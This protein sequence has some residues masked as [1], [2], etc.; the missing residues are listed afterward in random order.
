MGLLLITI[1]LVGYLAWLLYTLVATSRQSL[2]MLATLVKLQS[3]RNANLGAWRNRAGRE[4]LQ[5]RI[6]ERL[7][8]EGE[9]A[10]PPTVPNP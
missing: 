5:A 9:R 1:G 10:D 8:K 2:V 6:Q 3:E 4:L 7:R